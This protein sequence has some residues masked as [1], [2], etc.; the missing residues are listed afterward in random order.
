MAVYS[1]IPGDIN[2]FQVPRTANPKD[3][4]CQLINPY[5]GQLN[6]NPPTPPNQV[7]VAVSPSVIAGLA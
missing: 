1:L 5:G 7:I 2:L 6:P 4:V 3:I